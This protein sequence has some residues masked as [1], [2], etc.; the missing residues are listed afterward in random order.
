MNR[1]DQVSIQ[2]AENG[3]VLRFFNVLRGSETV[4]IFESIGM[5]NVWLQDN[6]GVDNE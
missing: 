4:L 3:Y 6:L 1:I 5:L 2:V